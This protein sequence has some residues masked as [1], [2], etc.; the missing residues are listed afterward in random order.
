MVRRTVWGD[1]SHPTGVRPHGPDPGATSRPRPTRRLAEA[2]QSRRGVGA[3]VVRHSS[4]GHV[5]G[6][7]V[8]RTARRAR[9]GTAGP[10]AR[11]VRRRRGRCSTPSARTLWAGVVDRAEGRLRAD[12]LDAAMHQPLPALTRAGGRRGPGPGRRRH[13]RGRHAAPAERL[14]GHPHAAGVRA[15]VGRGRDSPGGRRS[16]CS[17]SPVRPHWP[18]SARC[19]RAL[20]AAQGRGGDGLD[21]PRRR[22][23]GGRGRARRPASQPGPG[24][25]A[26]ALHRARVRRCTPGSPTSSG[27]RAGSAGAPACCCTASW[28]R[29]AVVGV[30]LVVDDRLDHR[31]AGHPV[32][33]HDD[34]RGPGR[35]ARAAP[36]R[37]C[38]RASAPCSGC[39]GCSAPT[40][41]PSGATSCRPARCRSRFGDLHFA[42]VEGTLRPA[43]TS[44]CASRPAPPAPWWVAPARAS[45]RWPPCCPAPSSPS[46]ARC[47]SAASTSLDLDLQQ[48][49]AAVGVVTQRTEI[50]AGHPRREHH[51]VRRPAA[52]RRSSAPSPSSA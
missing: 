42:Y 5:P 1:V 14:A 22:D 6:L 48:L 20:S 15:A 8:R 32:P 9:H 34:V 36:A 11:R 44:T 7:V 51:A 50:L 38:R 49:R 28:P 10:A 35:P 52:R 2:A 4:R 18:P 43:A 16:S 47:S 39:A 21:R 12:L 41:S 23:G 24:L 25:R 45:R 3:R 33:G 29:T 27:S 26:P 46:R 17:R 30:T 37:T 19:C 40:A 31:V 13:P